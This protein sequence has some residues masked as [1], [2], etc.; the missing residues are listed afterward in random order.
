MKNQ[1][2]QIYGPFSIQP[3]I[4]FFFVLTF[5]LL[6]WFL[7]ENAW[8]EVWLVGSGRFLAK[9]HLGTLRNCSTVTTNLVVLARI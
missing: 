1:V 2:K 4:L 3:I 5:L 7:S 6:E 9:T 8:W